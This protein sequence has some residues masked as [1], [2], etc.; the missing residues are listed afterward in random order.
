MINIDNATF[1]LPQG[2]SILKGISCEI[3]THDFI[4]LLGSNGSG[5]STLIKLLNRSYKLSSGTIIL[6]GQNIEKFSDNVYAKKTITLTQFVRES[7]FFDLTI[8][9]NALMIET[10][11]TP[12]QFSRKKFTEHLKDY[13]YGFNA[14][15]VDSLKSPLYNLSGGEQQILAFALYLRHQPDLLL[16]DEHTSALD[17]KTATKIMQFTADIIKEKE[18][19]CI[20]T[21]HNLD[22]ATQYGNR[23]LAL[24]DGK[25]VFD[26]LD[27]EAQR[28]ERQFLLEKC[29]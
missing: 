14:K 24:N 21:T 19:T 20:M 15:L 7:L 8:E 11:Y 6:N 4:V 22:F 23:V 27:N 9:E 10:A 26:S 29:Y 2:L 12:E 16:L 25:L 5:K 18:L 1:T 13:L 28:F 3:K 17:P